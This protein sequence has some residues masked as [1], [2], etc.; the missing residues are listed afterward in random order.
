MR[1]SRPFP[2][3]LY[4]VL[5][6]SHLLQPLRCS[7]QTTD[8]A[9]WRNGYPEVCQGLWYLKS[10]LYRWFRCQEHQENSGSWPSR[11]CTCA[12]TP[13]TC[14][15]HWVVKWLTLADYQS[16]DNA[17]EAGKGWA[18]FDLSS[19]EVPAFR[20][21]TQPPTLFVICMADVSYLWH[22]EIVPLYAQWTALGLS[23]FLEQWTWR[24]KKAA[25]PVERWIMGKLTT[26]VWICQLLIKC[27][28]EKY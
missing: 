13:Q 26:W 22:Q 24:G 4:L 16:H 11:V 14:L 19:T 7:G 17:K 1:Q 12:R 9:K 2:G 25:M 28:K 27:Q 18:A 23:L 6:S 3:L 5:R 8:P 10:T 21:E 20:S 15:S